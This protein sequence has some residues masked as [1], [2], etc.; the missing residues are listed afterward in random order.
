MLFFKVPYLDE[1]SVFGQTLLYDCSINRVEQNSEGVLENA[2]L[3]FEK[4]IIEVGEFSKKS[5]NSCFSKNH[6]FKGKAHFKRGKGVL[7]ISISS[8]K[9][10]YARG[11]LPRFFR[12]Y[13]FLKEGYFFKEKIDRISKKPREHTKNFY[14]VFH[15]FLCPTFL[16][17]PKIRARNAGFQFLLAPVCNATVSWF[18]FEHHVCFLYDLL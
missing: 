10:T 8:S 1:K 16:Y 18:F 6:L 11:N 9:R 13:D 7:Q 3:A 5:K 2:F 15:S 4:M 17:Q 14:S 12:T